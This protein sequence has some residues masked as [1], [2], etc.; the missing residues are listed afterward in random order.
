MK[1]KTSRLTETTQGFCDIIDITAKIAA[2]VREAQIN[3]GLLT[4]F[5]SGSTAALTTIEHEPGLVQDLKDLL[6]QLIPSNTRYHHDERWAT[7]T[8]SLIY[9]QRYSAPRCKFQLYA[10]G[11]FSAP[12]STSFFS[13]SITGRAHETSSSNS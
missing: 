12:G 10:A 1:V 9:A 5:V 13:I 2:Q 11:S 7:K 4:V 6:E 3:D 8:A